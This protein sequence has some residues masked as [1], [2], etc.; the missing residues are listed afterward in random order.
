VAIVRM[1]IVHSLEIGFKYISS[2]IFN[3]RKSLRMRPR[4]AARPGFLLG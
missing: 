4:R 1:H 3:Q 2:P